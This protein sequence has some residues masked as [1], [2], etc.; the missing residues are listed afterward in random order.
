MS[1]LSVSLVSIMCL[2]LNL[3][4]FDT[5]ACSFISRYIFRVW[6]PYQL[7]NKNILGCD[8][9]NQY[10]FRQ[11][12]PGSSCIDKTSTFRIFPGLTTSPGTGRTLISD[13]VP[14]GPMPGEPTATWSRT[15]V[16]WRRAPTRSCEKGLKTRPRAASTSSW[17]RPRELRPETLVADEGRT[18]FLAFPL[19]LTD[20]QHPDLR[21][22]LF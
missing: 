2:K 1:N 4:C 6:T 14:A 3:E 17:S 5:P 16:L 22:S 15:R 7:E 19:P 8:D 20:S 11:T 18:S 10:D 12:L 13:T 9:R 21:K